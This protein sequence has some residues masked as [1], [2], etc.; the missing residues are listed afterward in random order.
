MGRSIFFWFG[1]GV[2]ELAVSIFVLVWFRFLCEN[3][4]VKM[5]R[6]ALELCI[7]KYH[8]FITRGDILLG[9]AC[10]GKSGNAFLHN[11]LGFSL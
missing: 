5:A 6:C 7:N 9:L 4:C 8:L 2:N 10:A 11:Q 3:G 1:L